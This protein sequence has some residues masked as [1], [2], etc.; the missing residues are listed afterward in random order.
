MDELLDEHASAGVV[1]AGAAI[2]SLCTA[3]KGAGYT[4]VGPGTGPATASQAAKNLFLRCNEIVQT[5]NALTGTGAKGR[6][7]GLG[8]LSNTVQQINGE[9]TNAQGS[10]ALRVPAGQFS[11]I[12]AR[13]NAL[14]YGSIASL[15]HI[16]AANSE[17]DQNA[18]M[19]ANLEA[20]HQEYQ[21]WNDLAAYSSSAD[22]RVQPVNYYQNDAATSQGDGA[23][24][25]RPQHDSP[26]GIFTEGGYGWGHRDETANEDAF[27][28]HS[29]SVTVGADYRLANAVFGAS[30]GFDRYSAS[31]NPTGSS[32]TE[33]EAV[34]GGDAR[35]D[36]YSGSLFALWYLGQF[37]VNG[38]VTYGHLQSDVTRVVDYTN[39][40]PGCT[41]CGPGSAA[42]LRGDP[43]G[44]V[45]AGAVTAQ[46]DLSVVGIDISPSVSANYR[47]AAIESYT[48][49]DP[50]A[51]GLALQYGEQNIE[52][53]RSIVGVNFAKVFSPSFGVLTP[54]FKA[55]WHH[56]FRDQPNNVIMR[57]A[58][59]VAGVS[60][61]PVAA[62]AGNF[63]FVS[64]TDKP[65][66]NF[67]I[68]GAG[69][70]ALLPNRLQTYIYYERLVGVSYLTDNALSA[71]VRAQF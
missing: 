24:S 9:E 18:P 64:P 38:I 44:H 22:W 67:G 66:S 31:F 37:S 68:V 13:L 48:E 60:G 29:Y 10:L 69:L 23:S 53:L 11:N 65:E 15:D 63:A 47:R 46:Y 4:A 43:D 5:A 27:R 62:D 71:G 25:Y 45:A 3:M 1:N 50:S 35:V 7:L 55:E 32:P 2:Q 14:R 39:A 51:S 49:S 58:T 17:A 6:S 57:Y 34:A 42:M 52:S 33:S 40:N 54:S 59:T 16:T 12:G 19:L 21:A 41:N 28:Y 26:F 56:E 70:T 36:G 20:L 61:T 8:A 30:V